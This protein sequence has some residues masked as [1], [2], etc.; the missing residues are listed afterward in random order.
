MCEDCGTF[1][2]CDVDVNVSSWHEQERKGY[3]LTMMCLCVKL[4]KDQ[5][6]WL[7]LSQLDAS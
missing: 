1:K 7:G 5:L 6:P 4:T 3:G 2:D